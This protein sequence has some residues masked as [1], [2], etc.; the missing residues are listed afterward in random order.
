MVNLK[1]ETI[2]ML[3]HLHQTPD[4]II[5]IGNEYTGERCTWEQFCELADQD[6][7]CSFGR[8]EVRRDLVI[9][10]KDKY[11]LYREEY[12]GSEW[13]DIQQ[14]FRM[15]QET[16]PLSDIFIDGNFIN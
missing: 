6:Y 1:D 16:A 8:A 15:P 7:D 10:F 9:V 2:Q 4:D 5:F 14:P 11:K 12:D 13:W 3:E